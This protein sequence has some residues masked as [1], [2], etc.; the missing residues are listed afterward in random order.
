M[1]RFQ[2]GHT[3]LFFNANTVYRFEN[4][5]DIKRVVVRGFMQSFI[6][7]IVYLCAIPL[8]SAQNDVVW[9]GDDFPYYQTKRPKEVEFLEEYVFECTLQDVPLLQQICKNVDSQDKNES[10]VIALGA[11]LS[12]SV[13]NRDL[14]QNDV[15]WCVIIADIRDQDTFEEKW[16][17]AQDLYYFYN[18]VRPNTL[19]EHI[20][21]RLVCECADTR[22]ERL[23]IKSA[24]YQ[25][26]NFIALR[27][28]IRNQDLGVVPFQMTSEFPHYS[29]PQH[30][31]HYL[32]RSVLKKSIEQESA[33][34]KFGFD[35]DF[36]DDEL[37]QMHLRRLRIAMHRE[38]DK[39]AENLS[40]IC[41][42]IFDE[43]N[44]RYKESVA[45]ANVEAIDGVSSVDVNVNV[46][47]DSSIM[48]SFCKRLS[49]DLLK[50]CISSSSKAMMMHAELVEKANVEA[51]DCKSLS[52]EMQSF[53]KRLSS[54]LLA[55]F[56]EVEAVDCKSLSSD[57]AAVDLD[58]ELMKMVR[59]FMHRVAK[60]CKKLVEQ[61]KS[62]A[63]WDLSLSDAYLCETQRICQFVCDK[64]FKEAA[65]MHK[66]SVTCANVK[67]GD[68]KILSFYDI[69]PST[70]GTDSASASMDNI[71]E[72]VRLLESQGPKVHL[73]T[74]SSAQLSAFPVVKEN[75]MIAAIDSFR[76]LPVSACVQ[77]ACAPVVEIPR[78]YSIRLLVAALADNQ[79]TLRFHMHE[80]DLCVEASDPELF[81]NLR[82]LESVF[83]SIFNAIRS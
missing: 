81:A 33:S 76:G 5:T 24:L 56:V 3:M 35:D 18:I 38:M 73:C 8:I 60:D 43:E 48:K 53:C 31:E 78:N 55:E 71:K 16:L 45:L 2:R 21:P 23:D 74:I 29:C 44:C 62:E 15:V 67:K 66:E 41:E 51:V 52:S 10:Y 4:K 77:A 14:V 83:Y 20:L 40:R 17:C 11:S 75:V 59:T 19:D 65:R 69:V 30:K 12:E 68:A 50:A 26:V 28:S 46:N 49:S 54:E 39:L 6:F 42:G 82:S 70:E 27:E 61:S 32:T 13:P 34:S 64:I 9:E 1:K 72:K 58:S 37:M 80:G 57:D 25:A 36:D 7:F 47:Y 79:S 63:M 22:I